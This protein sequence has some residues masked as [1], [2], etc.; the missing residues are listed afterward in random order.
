MKYCPHCG[1]AN[2]DSANYCHKCG[3]GFYGDQAPQASVEDSGK[4]AT[5]PEP[6]FSQ[7]HDSTASASSASPTLPNV[8][9]VFA[10][11]SLL[12]IAPI[13]GVVLSIIGLAKYKDKASRIKCGISLGISLA[14]MIA[15]TL[16]SY[17]VL[18]PR[19]LE[20]LRKTEEMVS[21]MLKES[22]AASLQ[23]TLFR[24]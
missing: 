9:M 22:T 17:F 13:V 15:W 1:E 21:S 12:D 16:F 7:Y 4:A 18:L 14:A 10:F 20:A 23:A 11:L 19:L 8:A 6:V 2:E 3:A 5:N 24:F